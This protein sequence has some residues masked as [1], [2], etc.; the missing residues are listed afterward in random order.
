MLVHPHAS[1][2]LDLCAHAAVVAL[3]IGIAAA[4]ARLKA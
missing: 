1:P 4:V 2:A 3:V